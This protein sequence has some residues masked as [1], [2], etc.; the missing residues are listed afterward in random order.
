MNP[1]NTLLGRCTVAYSE[2]FEAAITSQAI[3]PQSR[4]RGV[5]AVLEHLAAELQ[6]LNSRSDRF[7]VHEAALMLR[8]EAAGEL[9]GWDADEA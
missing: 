9:A 6:T 8:L 7:S 1:D 5:A 4:R 2:A 3:A